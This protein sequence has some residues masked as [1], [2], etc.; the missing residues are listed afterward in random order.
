MRNTYK[1][2]L[3][4]S[5]SLFLAVL[6]LGQEGTSPFSMYG[7][8]NLRYQGFA[9][10]RA[11]GGLSSPLYSP[12]H[13]NPSNPASYS[14]IMQN[15]FIFEM[16]VTG[17]N[18]ILKTPKKNY[19]DF[20]ANVSYLSIGFPVAKWWRMGLGLIPLSSI[21]YNIQQEIED[22]VDG[23]SLTTL[24]SGEGGITNF[25]FD[26]S[27]KIVK[28]LSVGVKVSY[29]FGPLIY[30]RT[31]ISYNENSVSRI[32][33]S[34]KANVSAFSYKAGIHYHKLLHENLFLNV[35][36]AYGFNTDLSAENQ[37][38]ITNTISKTN[39]ILGDTLLD[40][41][42]DIGVLEIP[43]SYSVGT[44][45]S[46]NNKFEFGFDY[47]MAYWSQSKFFDKNY[48]FADQSK[49]AFGAEYTPDVMSN[50]YINLIRYRIGA[51]I[52]NS[53]LVYEGTQL[54]SY[55]ISMGFGLPVKRSPTIIN[56][57]VSYQKKYIPGIDIVEENY[58]MFQL[59]LSL[60]DIWFKKRVWQ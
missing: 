34:D 41:T 10:N 9:R 18:I 8:G 15:S 58:L 4:L 30:K 43:Q 27:F 2:I 37:T 52:T 7:I 22:E 42:Q 35:G 17:N 53:Y 36:A 49:L 28:S 47:S 24:Y 50:K 20:D 51:N 38:L 13:L 57:A 21:G 12:Y 56:F 3:G 32:E 40:V 16:G 26:N 33:R 25:Y 19:T 23:Q 48:T 1:R 11:M 29:L 39:T 31:S 14:A 60:Q 46:I 55:E 54:K 6:V 59:N 45:L 44:S 5:F